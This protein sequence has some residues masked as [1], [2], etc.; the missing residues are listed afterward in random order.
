MCLEEYLASSQI[1]SKKKIPEDSCTADFMHA[2][3]C[4]VVSE[5]VNVSK[6]SK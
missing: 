4:Y 6:K 3:E 2:L 5:S 1:K